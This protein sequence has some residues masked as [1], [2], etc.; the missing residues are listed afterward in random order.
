MS[1]QREYLEVEPAI[2]KAVIKEAA[3]KGMPVKTFTSLVLGDALDK[4][5]SGSIQVAA[6]TIITK[7]QP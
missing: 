1:A 2:K 7:D 5:R 3:R 4:L 6:P